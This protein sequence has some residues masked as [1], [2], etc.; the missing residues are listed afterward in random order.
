MSE[1]QQST[2]STIAVGR[3]IQ[4]CICQFASSTS[5]KSWMSTHQFPGGKMFIHKQLSI[6]FN[7][8]TGIWVAL[9]I[10]ISLLVCRWARMRNSVRIQLQV[11]LN[12]ALNKR[13]T[14]S[15]IFLPIF[16]IFLSAKSILTPIARQKMPMEMQVSLI[17]TN[18]K[19]CIT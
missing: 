18:P 14:S 17:S 5:L 15:L 7:Q 11:H 12:N 3:L 8:R 19:P 13:V 16:I 9:P 6:I 1:R 2:I 4:L 10:Q